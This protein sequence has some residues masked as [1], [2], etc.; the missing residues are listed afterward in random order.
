MCDFRRVLQC[1][2]C[3]AMR[4]DAMRGFT[5][6]EMLS[7]RLAELQLFLGPSGNGSANDDER[8]PI[9]RNEHSIAWIGTPIH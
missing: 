5:S 8:F 3:H 7:V 6:E 9:F 2:S 1:N 4:C